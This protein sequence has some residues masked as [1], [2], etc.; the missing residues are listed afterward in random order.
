MNAVFEKLKSN[1]ELF[2]NLLPQ[3]L[4]RQDGTYVLGTGGNWIDGFYVGTLNI[5]YLLSGENVFREYA[6]QYRDFYKL[7]IQNT[8][9]RIMRLKSIVLLS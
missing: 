8:E 6:K 3:S 9:C 4:M 1:A 5:A 7:R 2:G